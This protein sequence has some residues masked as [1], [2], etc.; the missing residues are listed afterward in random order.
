MHIAPS[1]VY[2]QIILWQPRLF[3]YRN[4]NM[5]KQ[6]GEQRGFDS[7]QQALVTHTNTRTPFLQLLLSFND[8]CCLTYE[9]IR[10]TLSQTK[11]EEAQMRENYGFCE[12]ATYEL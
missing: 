9:E 8:Y 10:L 12:K 1:S 6:R 11:K 3:S 2:A 7:A 4:Q 5:D